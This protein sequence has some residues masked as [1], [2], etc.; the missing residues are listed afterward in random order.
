M[1]FQAHTFKQ[2]FQHAI[3]I[4]ILF[5]ILFLQAK[6]SKSGVHF[7]FEAIEG[8]LFQGLHSLVLLEDTI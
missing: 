8:S 3:N 4:K 1:F 6:T 2:L 5:Y 7:M